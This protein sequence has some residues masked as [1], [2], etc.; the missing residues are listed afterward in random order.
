MYTFLLIL[1]VLDSFVV[2]GAVL[3]Q[4]GK[5]GGLAAQF[6]GVSTSTDALFGTRQAGNVLTKT[7]WWGGALFLLLAF[8][9]ALASARNR[10]PTSV[11]DK[12]VATP[13]VTAPATRGAAPAIPLG[14]PSAPA[15][16]AKGAA[17]TPV[18][19]AKP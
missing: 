16:P 15:A 5:G 3:V 19:G 7:S 1:L 12:V 17:T 4:S 11:L 2:I 6:G 10:A 18:P 13:P 9:L 8:V 14:T